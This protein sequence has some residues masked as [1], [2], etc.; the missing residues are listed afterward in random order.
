M[1]I[2]IDLGTS[3]LKSILIDETQKVVA[4]ASEALSVQRPDVGWAEQ[5]PQSWIDAARKT[6]LKLK[7]DQPLAMAKVQ[8]IGL[9][10]H[11]HGATLVDAAGDTL[12]P[13]MLWND[14]RSQAQAAV[15]DAKQ[16]FRRISGNVVFP[17]F[18]APKV[19]WVGDHEPEVFA[20]I[21]KVLL[22]KDYLRFWLTGDYVSEMSDAAGTSWL[23]VGARK[24]SDTLLAQTHLTPNQMPRL[25][26]GSS[27]SAKLKVELADQFGLPKNVVVAGGAGDNAAAACGLGT[28]QDGEA[29]VSLGTSGVLFAAN[30]SYRP[31]PESAV[32]AFCHALPD[33][34][35]QMGVILSATDSLNWYAKLVG[36]DAATLVKACGLGLSRP[37]KT[38]FLPYLSGER[39]PHNDAN[40]RGAFLGLSH[41]DDTVALTRA[42]LE[43]V[44]FALKDNLV[45]LNS[46]GTVV[47][48]LLATGGG[49]A[50]AYW[51]S[52]LATV[53][54]TPISVPQNADLGAALGAARL[55]MTAAGISIPDAMPASKTT[56]TFEPDTNL[57]DA[58]S[59][60]HQRFARLYEAVQPL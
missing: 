23:D 27:V 11:M 38:L 54:N 3:S 26:E 24:W 1:F 51:L 12:R 19:A 50:S 4:T 46:T 45:A 16:D 8:A 18:T 41:A 52:L 9:A 32:H 10:G 36:S 37:S 55:A 60:A 20:K 53:L 57:V 56:Q 2:G 15:L 47:S 21:H 28:I 40:V 48:H 25:V 49:A 5:S 14:T 22:P 34:W 17:G 6:L 58:Y 59:T 35:H 31:K 42:V 43:G 29:F 7:Q 33:T 39:T 44:S 30:K 13:C